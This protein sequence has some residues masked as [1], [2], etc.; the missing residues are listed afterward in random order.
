MTAGETWDSCLEEIR[1]LPSVQKYGDDVKVSMYEYS[2]PSYKGLTY[3]IECY[4]PTWVIPE[5]HDVTKALEESYKNLFGEARIAPVGVA[6]NTL[7][8]A[9]AFVIAIVA[10]PMGF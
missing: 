7:I 8:M 5:D 4:F 2:R 6:F 10:G 9:A 3:P 1:Q